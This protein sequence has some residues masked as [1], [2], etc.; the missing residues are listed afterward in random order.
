MRSVPE[1]L[2]TIEA[3]LGEL[4]EQLTRQFSVTPD[5]GTPDTAPFDL[6]D[7]VLRLQRAA[8][9]VAVASARAL[10][11]WDDQRAWCGKG[12]RSAAHRLANDAHRSLRQARTEL[13]RARQLEAMP[14]AATA[15]LAGRLSIDHVDLLGRA[16]RPWRDAVFAEHEGTLVEQCA[17]LRWDQA[18]RLV[19]YWVQ[20]VDAVAAEQA[21]QVRTSDVHCWAS[22]TFQGTVVI[23]AQ[24]DPIGGAVFTTE[25]ERLEREL[26]LADQAT[27]ADRTSRQ[28]R[29]AA[30]VEMAARSA[31]M[32]EG[33]RRPAPLFTVLVGD[34]TARH[35]CELATSR[36]VLHP[37][38]LL[39]YL[40][41]ALVESVIFDGPTDVLAVS[42]RRTFTGA[43]R[44]A[45]EV[46][47]RECQ[48]P[49]GCD[50]AAHLCDVDHIVPW[51]TGGVT[52][53]RNGRLLCAPHNRRA[54]L[55]HHAD[56]LPEGHE[57]PSR[58][59]DCVRRRRLGV[60]RARLRWRE[61]Q[62]AGP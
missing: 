58:A 7:A 51:S 45:I 36:T 16:Q 31:A 18:S 22:T 14:A 40:D 44:R 30:L 20:H 35:L 50:T 47:D 59:N 53:Q 29:A 3:S 56:P 25:L 39:G 6:H 26:W 48:H 15:V 1:L 52:H 62:R 9:T 57:A 34:Q 24:L 12:H 11:A 8:S 37:T 49:S 54:D 21:D 13:R 28:R 5:T 61:L 42:R 46:R 32:P 43:L 33:S 4:A 19:D 41:A 10:V 2:D 38:E 23:D 60:I 17:A 55:R 27:G